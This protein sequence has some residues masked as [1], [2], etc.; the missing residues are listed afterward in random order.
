MRLVLAYCC[1]FIS[2]VIKGQGDYLQTIRGIVSDSRTQQIIVGATVII[3]GEEQ[4]GTITDEFGRFKFDEIPV[5]RVSIR[6]SYIGYNTFQANNLALSTGKELIVN[7]QLE[8]RIEELQEVEIKANK[9][10]D[11]A[12][13]KMASIS[14][15][16]FTIEETERYAGSLGDPSRMAANFAGVTMTSDQRNDIVIRGNSPMGLLWRFEGTDV[17]NPNHFGS[18]GST[19]GP[20]SMLNNNVLTNSDFYTGAFPAEYGNALAGVFDLRMRNGNNEKHEFMGQI[21]FNGFEA[22]AEGPFSKNSQASYLVNFR[23]STLEALSAIGMDFGTGAA[24]PQYKD[25]TYKVNVPIKK[26]RISA[27]GIGGI[28]YIEMLD[29]KGD[30]STYGW[31]GTDIYFGANMGATGINWLHFFNENTR[32]STTLATTR[33]DNSTRLF[34]LSDNSNVEKILEKHSETRYSINSVLSTKLNNRNHLNY[35]ITLAFYD[36]NYSGKRWDENWN[37]YLDYLSN[38]GQINT[39][40]VF[41]EWQHHFNDKFVV[42]SGLHSQILYTNN[43]WTAEPRLGFRY[44]VKDNQSL[45]F[46]LGFHSQSQVKA[47]YF[48]SIISDTLNNEITYTNKNLDFSKSIH[49]ILGYD[50]LLTENQRIK[51]E[52]YYQ[53]LYNLPVSSDQ[54]QYSAINQGGDFTYWVFNWMENKGQG[55]NYGVELTIEKFLSKGFYYL[56]T[57]SLFDSKYT[58][59]DGIKR[60]TAFNGNYVLN[61]LSGY[62]WLLNNRNTLAFDIKMVVAGG[63]RYIPIDVEKSKIAQ[64]AVYDWDNAYT[65]RLDNYFRIN[66]RLTY[67]INYKKFMQEWGIDIQNLTN[68]QNIF[69][70]TWD[71]NRNQLVTY[72]QMGFMPMMTYKIYF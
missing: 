15:R 54:P 45:N 23:Y 9:R 37:K 31:A 32:I 50:I 51:F 61:V 62:E 28:S 60:N 58:G 57:A 65:K 14:A 64:S 18:M 59:F 52:T 5:G 8:E 34:D 7:V 26:G 13:N 30:S 1:V 67:R 56:L 2:L 42:N 55:E 6:V 22:G 27:Y 72:Y 66:T 48:T 44:K 16:S 69:N 3:L 40:Q 33:I 70:Q 49:A 41:A 4:K 47:I 24:I 38:V 11:E 21:G 25:L 43:T 39:S 46:G 53:Y 10:K 71:S 35:G 20:V 29:S 68:H 17:P 63:K 36:V 12:I 19:G